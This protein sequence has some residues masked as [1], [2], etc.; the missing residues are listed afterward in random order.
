MPLTPRYS[1][2]QLIL[3]GDWNTINYPF[4]IVFLPGLGSSSALICTIKF[5]N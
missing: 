3:G 1:S 4:F 5:P 2:A